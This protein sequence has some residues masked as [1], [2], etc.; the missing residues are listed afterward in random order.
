M[1]YQNVGTPRFYVDILSYLNI[2]GHNNMTGVG[3][4]STPT[5]NTYSGTGMINL[6]PQGGTLNIPKGTKLNFWATLGHNLGKIAIVPHFHKYADTEAGWSQ[7]QPLHLEIINAG[8]A[9][10]A[11]SEFISQYDGFT[12]TEMTAGTSGSSSFNPDG[13]TEDIIAMHLWFPQNGPEDSE[14]ESGFVFK[15]NSVLMGQYYD[16]PHSPDLNLTMTREM[17][18][19]KRIRTRGGNELIN[20]KYT[21]PPLWGNL[22]PWELG[23]AGNQKMAR[24]GRRIW[25]LNFSFLKDK[26]I[27][28][29]L[30]NIGYVEAYDDASSASGNTLL[31]D[32][33]FYSQ[34]IHKTNGGQ[35]P[36]IFQP[37]NLNTDSFA[38]CKFDMNSFQ[39]NQVANGVYNIKLKIR[40]VW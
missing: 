12:I 29:D 36:F 9:I 8:T 10:G 5:E 19:I 4:N 15:I 17:D 18:G 1:A 33:T 27:F 11:S 6:H 22:A 39:F 28:P 26:V 7:C 13:N 30:S 25:D 40:E 21:K 23:G 16:M 31:D 38:I 3:I 20:K 2:I 37:D 35:L 32:N 24:S 14:I 34:V